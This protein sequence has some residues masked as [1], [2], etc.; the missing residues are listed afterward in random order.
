M[1]LFWIGLSLLVGAAYIAYNEYRRFETEARLVDAFA[2]V[3]DDVVDLHD[4]ITGIAYDLSDL[5]TIVELQSRPMT[6]YSGGV[7]EFDWATLPQ[8]PLIPGPDAGIA[9][10]GLDFSKP[11]NDPD[12]GSNNTTGG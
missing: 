11:A 9:F 8:A 7:T 5:E 3:S 4:Y 2:R 6:P 10:F 1:N 12:A